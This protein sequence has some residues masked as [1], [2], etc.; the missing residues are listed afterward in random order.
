MTKKLLM[1]T[2]LLMAVVAGKA[3]T[4]LQRHTLKERTVPSMLQT[5]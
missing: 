4:A 3:Q 5:K 2:V 1:M